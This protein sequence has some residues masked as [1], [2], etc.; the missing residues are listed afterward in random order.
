MS[1]THV[2]MDRDGRLTLPGAVREVL[3]LETGATF[4]VEVEGDHLELTPVTPPPGPGTSGKLVDRDGLL[5]L[6][7]NGDPFDAVGALGELRES[8][9]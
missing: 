1:E 7:R 3:R 6:S 8:R 4:R 2:T 9:R 5:V